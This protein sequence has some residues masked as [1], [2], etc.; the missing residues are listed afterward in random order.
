M[1]PIPLGFPFRLDDEQLDQAIEEMLEPANWPGFEDFARLL[2][3]LKLALI[4]AGFRERQRRDQAAS[5]TQALRAAYAILG[6]SI[7]TLIVA[8]LTAVTA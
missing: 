8:V 3:E 5:A 6:V 1:P 4:A 2:P 7:V